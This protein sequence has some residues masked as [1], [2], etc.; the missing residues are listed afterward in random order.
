MSDL[1]I[2]DPYDKLVAILSNDVQD[3]CYFYSAPFKETINNE[4]SFEF[5]AQGNHED[6]AYIVAEN[7][8]AFKDKDGNLRLFVI[9]EP[10]KVNGEEGPEIKVYAEPAMYELNDEIIE[11]VRPYNTTA[12]DALSRALENTRWSAGIVDELGIS[13]TNFY[14]IT[15]VKAIENILDNWG[16]EVIDRVEFDGNKITGRYIDILFRRGQDIGKVWEIDKDIISISHKVLSYPKTA[17]YGRGSGL[18]TENGGYTRKINFADVEWIE[19][20][21]DP[22]DKPLGQEW[23]GDPEALEAFGRLNSDMTK[24]HRSGIYE[25]DETD[26]VVLLQNTWNALQEQKVQIENFELTTILLGELAGYEHE[27]VRI[28]DTTRAVDN[29]FAASIQFQARI[30]SFEYDVSDPDESATIEMG[31]YIDLFDESKRLDEIESKLNSRAPIWDKAEDPPVI[32]DS[33]FP[34]TVPPVPTSFSAQ[35]LFKTVK[36]NW[37]YNH[38]SYIAAYE[39]YASQIQG[40]TP[41]SDNL[42]FRGKT[43]G[44]IFEADTD[45]QWYFKAR[46]MNTHGTYSD[47]TNEIVAQTVR[48]NGQ[49]VAPL[50]ITNELLANDVSADKITTG[51]L[52]AIAIE[53]VTI[54]GSVFRSVNGNFLVDDTGVSI[55]DNLNKS[56]MDKDGFT[57]WYDATGNEN[58]EK[59]FYLS[60]DETVSKKFRAKE[61]FTMG[62]VKIISIDFPDNKG[63]A[64]V[65]TLTMT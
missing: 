17:L 5:I 12:S 23:V 10:E 33:N 4:V 63:W 14:Y 32:D 37:D 26:P 1:F 54:T 8:V 9:K 29:S 53:G 3:A 46:S 60:D 58:W 43:S 47:F 61:E 48:V 62:T 31:Q 51:T 52:K 15:V 22:T 13:S 41:D 56:T 20:N 21:G 49:D 24:R 55:K 11:D 42:V 18:E 40:F 6:S 57:G 36:L 28:G 16:G 39:I 27:K 38:E 44:V 65:P 35:G 7:Q 64:I 30:I 50:T 59:I 25:G 19:A 2:F 34:D 45:S